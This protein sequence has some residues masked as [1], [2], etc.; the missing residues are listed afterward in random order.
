MK[1]LVEFIQENFKEAVVE[2]ADTVKHVKL[3]FDKLDGAADVI[4][5]IKSM[6]SADSVVFDTANMGDGIKITLDA[7]K[8]DT[9]DKIAELVQEFI[10]AA[11]KTDDEAV[12]AAL[13]KLSGQ[14]GALNDA[15]D[16]FGAD[17]ADDAADKK[18]G[19][20]EE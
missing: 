7:G 1:S 3:S 12:S 6:C 13:E 15:I 8:A 14:L 2:A 19:S 9:L 5:S 16:D 4:A 18:D 20:E 10:S 11:G 17:G